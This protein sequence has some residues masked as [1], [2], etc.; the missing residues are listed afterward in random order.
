MSPLSFARLM[1]AGQFMI[2]FELVRLVGEA[3]G[4][5]QLHQLFPKPGQLG[6]LLGGQLLLLGYGCRGF[7]VILS[8]WAL[9][10]S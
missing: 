2:G 9:A 8:L 5:I 3:V 6:F 1:A 4:M 7:L 10:F